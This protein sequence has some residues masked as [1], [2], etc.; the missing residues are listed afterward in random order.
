MVIIFYNSIYQPHCTGF[1]LGQKCSTDWLQ[2]AFLGLGAGYWV[3]TSILIQSLGTVSFV[4]NVVSDFLQILEVG[5]KEEGHRTIHGACYLLC[6]YPF[7]MALSATR[8]Q[9][10]GS[11]TV[12]PKLC[13]IG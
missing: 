9:T 6:I 3:Q 13:S 12:K 11:A 1:T 2:V 5:P 4:V 8:I 10:M 7:E